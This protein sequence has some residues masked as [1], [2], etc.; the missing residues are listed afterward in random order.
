MGCNSIEPEPMSQ[1]L[2]CAAQLHSV[3]FMKI[4]ELLLAALLLL[5]PLAVQAV[6]VPGLFEAEVPVA[7]Q[8][9]NM[10]VQAIEVAMKMVLVKLTGDRNAPLRP[11]LIP[12]VKSAEKYVQQYRYVEAPAKTD[13]PLADEMQLRLK[14]SFDEANLGNA[15]R[16][17]GVQLWG[18]ERPSTLVWLA[19][20]KDQIRKLLIPEEDAEYFATIN[21][22]SAARGTVLM[23]PL[24]DLEDSSSLQAS[25]I[26]AEFQD[27][28]VKAS[29]RY[30]PDT[31]LTGWIES[32]LEG[33]W[34]ARWTAYFGEDTQ[35]WTTEGSYAETVLAEGIDGMA[36][37]LA[38]RYSQ[39]SG[40]AT[41]NTTIRVLDVYTV[42]NYTKVL[43][44][45]KTLSPVSRVE[46]VEVNTG[47]TEFRLTAHGG[48][49]AV[50]QAISFGRILEPATTNNNLY[51]L[52][53]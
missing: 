42:E 26:R 46:V 5:V 39:Q 2:T 50:R 14:I 29:Q 45:L 30:S 20:E 23:Y 37:L 27:T 19:M 24:F 16:E 51:R 52:L 33:I 48:E 21:R 15:L 9:A 12:V 18:R 44:Y 31:I 22:Q 7:G 43:A 8:Q 17:T 4:K 28:V 1:S 53:P 6:R 32:P 34:Q 49:Q 38:T 13:D 25:D 35:S 47:N 10:R 41:G 11:E 3:L 36:D 40:A